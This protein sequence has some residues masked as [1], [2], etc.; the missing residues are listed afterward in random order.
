LP[1]PVSGYRHSRY[2]RS[3][4]GFG[5]PR[6]L[7]AAD[8]WLLERPI[9]G[10][11]VRDAM[12]CYPLFSCSRW[13][14]LADDLAAIGEDLVSVVLVADPLGDHS[15]A[16][17]ERCF[18]RVEG[19]KI[20]H[21]VDFRLPGAGN[22][23]KHHR[24]YARRAL[25]QIAVEV[26]PDPYDLLDDWCRLYVHVVNRHGLTGI[27]AFSRHAFAEQLRVP[28]M[29]ALRATLQGITVG[30][31]LFYEQGRDA[32]S[33][34]GAISPLGYETGAAYA[35]HATALRLFATR[36]DRLDLGGAAGATLADGDGLDQFKRGWGNT[37]ATAYLC[38][39]ILDRRRYDD[40]RRSRQAAPS[41]Y[42]PAY[43]NGELT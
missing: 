3:L 7:P 27:K 8:G 2:A 26:I 29:V 21:V 22:P 32:Y 5:I 31:H 9:P 39:R 10:T 4:D 15:C 6:H 34:L 11:E 17:L 42:F 19:Y 20:H 16:Q 37:T 18:D 30:A 23:S 38:G 28:G 1:E 13:E 35:L 12:G 14:S 33:H 25:Q 24:Y 43:R 36:V 41:G 40:L